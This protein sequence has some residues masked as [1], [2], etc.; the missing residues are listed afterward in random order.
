MGK[1]G[2]YS[3]NFHTQYTKLKKGFFTLDFVSATAVATAVASKIVHAHK[4]KVFPS[5]S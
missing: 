1:F 4:K 3:G 5:T 2:V